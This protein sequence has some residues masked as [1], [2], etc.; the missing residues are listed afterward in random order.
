MWK[1]PPRLA[2]ARFVLPKRC[3]SCC[4]FWQQDSVCCHKRCHCCR[5]LSKDNPALLPMPLPKLAANDRC[6]QFEWQQ[7]EA[8]MNCNVGALPKNVSARMDGKEHG[9]FVPVLVPILREQNSVISSPPP[10]LF[11]ITGNKSSLF[12]SLFPN[13]WEQDSFVPALVPLR[14]FLFPS[15]SQLDF[16]SHQ[17]SLLVRAV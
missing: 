1:L 8:G 13:S 3:H 14:L 9:G 17:Q 15:A 5:Q 6:F 4:H 7:T 16:I 11:P 2:A 12:P 10:W